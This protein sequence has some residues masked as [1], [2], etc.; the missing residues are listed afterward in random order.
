MNPAAA[1]AIEQL[2]ELNGCDLHLT[3]IPSPG[4]SAGLRKLGV[5]ATSD[6]E[7]ASKLLYMA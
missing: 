6:P 4:D 2:K 5:Q 3:H 7:F 1:M